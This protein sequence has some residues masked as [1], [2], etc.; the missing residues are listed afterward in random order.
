MIRGT[1]VWGQALQN[2]LAQLGQAYG[3]RIQSD[4]RKEELGTLLKDK[5]FERTGI[6]YQ[7]VPVNQPN[8]QGTLG[9]VPVPQ[10]YN[11][12]EKVGLFDERRVGDLLRALQLDP[13]VV[14]AH[15]ASQ[16]TYFNLGKDDVRFRQP[17]GGG[18]PTPIAAGPAS[19]STLSVGSQDW[20]GEF[21]AQGRPV[22]EKVPGTGKVQQREFK[23]IPDVN[24]PGKMVKIYKGMEGT[25][26]SNSNTA[27]NEDD[28]MKNAD[29][30]EAGRQPP[31]FTGFGRAG[32]GKVKAELERRQFNLSKATREWTSV[33]KFMAT[34]N[35]PQQTRL[36]E[37]IL[38]AHETVGKIE[39]LYSQLQKQ[40]LPTGYKWWNRAAMEAAKAIPGQ[41]GA[42]A[43]SLDTAINDFA[44]ELGGI[45]MGGNTPTDQAMKRASEN[46]R[47]EW[48]PETVGS[49]IRLIK[50]LLQY[51]Q[52][53][54]ENVQPIGVGEN[55]PYI[56]PPSQSGS[57][58]QEAI[59]WAKQNPNDP[60]AK[61]ILRMN[62]IQ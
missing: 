54:I 16:P 14:A 42:T 39:E 43:Q 22:Y 60:R 10:A 18:L 58:D 5:E 62:G 19:K 7:D 36:R 8:G 25:S 52:S 26:P 9:N 37:N 30:I 31:V 34:L 56:N 40:G 17:A 29:A 15:S 51:R 12:Q 11:Y 47:A 53:S 21:D 57:G 32:A 44:S 41:A 28:I 49:N 45:Y 50:S 1:D 33:Q 3:Q 46:L 35:G 27:L 61:E 38:F 2:A 48:N 4:A 24:N 23:Y 59:D 55:S 20:Q 13:N 6:T